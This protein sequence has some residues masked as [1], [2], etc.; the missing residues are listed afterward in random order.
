MKR[1]EA[2]IARRSAQFDK[3][4][5][6]QRFGSTG[7]LEDAVAFF[8]HITFFVMAFQDVLRLNQSA[9]KD[10]DLRWLAEHH[11][12]EDAGHEDWF[13]HDIEAFGVKPGVD[14]AFGP[15][16]APTRDTG[17]RLVAAALRATYDVSRISL[18]LAL[19]ATGESIFSR[20]P[21][22]LERAGNTTQLK[23]FAK[24]HHEVERAH[25]I[26]EGRIREILN[27]IDLDEAQLAEATAVVDETFDA[28]TSM[29]DHID[30]R[31]FR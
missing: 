17:Y 6:F 5:I 16:H 25:E 7:P 31:L 3:H 29:L 30:R 11:R 18:V 26:H 1:I 20:M 8:P 28:M 13:L 15:E 9:V 10:P 14:W 27:N 19:E 22:Y 23:Y 21:G 12:E 4:P 2:Q 24:S